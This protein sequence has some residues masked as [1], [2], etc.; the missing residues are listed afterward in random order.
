LLSHSV[1]YGDPAAAGG[2][3]RDRL[4]ESADLGTTAHFIPD[5]NTWFFLRVASD[6]RSRCLARSLHNGSCTARG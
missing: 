2:E 1:I 3:F 6:A 5:E 4:A